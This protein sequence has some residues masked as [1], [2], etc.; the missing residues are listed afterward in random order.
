MWKRVASPTTA[1]TDAHRGQPKLWYANLADTTT[2][3]IALLLDVNCRWFRLWRGRARH[4]RKIVTSRSEPNPRKSFEP[5]DRKAPLPSNSLAPTA[6]AQVGSK[7]SPNRA[8]DNE[9]IF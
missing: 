3:A 1:G 7:R 2:K 4:S 9:P 5:V 8:C 6:P